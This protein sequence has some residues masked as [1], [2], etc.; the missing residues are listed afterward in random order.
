MIKNNESVEKLNKTIRQ[1]QELGL[2]TQNIGIARPPIPVKIE[3]INHHAIKRMAERGMKESDA[4]SFIENAMIMFV[5]DEGEKR[6]YISQDGNAVILVEGTKLIS[7]YSSAYFD[8]GMK[9]IINEVK[10]YV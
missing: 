1:M 9:R 7:A 3:Y 4:Q 10:K 2:V 6:L 5:Q 8:E